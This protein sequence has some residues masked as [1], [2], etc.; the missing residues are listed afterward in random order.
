MT[1]GLTSRPIAG[2]KVALAPSALIGLVG[3]ALLA[4]G[5]LGAVLFAQPA[6]LPV[7]Q[8]AGQGLS[9]QQIVI[10]GEVADRLAQSAGQ[11]LSPQ[12]IVI[13]G[14]VADRL[15]QSASQG[16]SPQQI[17]IRGEIADHFEQ[18]ANQGTPRLDPPT[19]TSRWITSKLATSAGQKVL[20]HG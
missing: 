16:L 20:V 18:M 2:T 6:Q 5:T 9:P 1:A 14:E 4:G 7:A 17:V 19:A 8:S 3:A 15:A 13:R 11:G 12:Q 10:R